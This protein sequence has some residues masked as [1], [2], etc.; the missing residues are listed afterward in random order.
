MSYLFPDCSVTRPVFSTS[1]PVKVESKKTIPE[2]Q[3]KDESESSDSGNDESG[4]GEDGNDDDDDNS[5][6]SGDDDGEGEEG[7]IKSDE[8][9]YDDV[10]T[11][12]NNNILDYSITCIQRSLKGSNESGLLQQVVFKCRFYE[13]DLR[14]VAVSEPWSLKASGLLIQVVSNTGLTIVQFESTCTRQNKCY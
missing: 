6:S 14:R 7:E 11:L 5:S 1:A 4:S 9:K 10:L 12:P 8:E 13:V 2:I 3:E